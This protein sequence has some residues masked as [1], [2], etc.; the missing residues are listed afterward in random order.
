MAKKSV[1]GKVQQAAVP[2][3]AGYVEL[4]EDLKRRIRE[5]RVR[6]A[7]SVNRELVLLYWHI[8]REILKRQKQEGWGA[9]VIERL[10]RDLRREFPD[11]K[12]F[13]PRNLKYMRAFAEAYPDEQFVQEVLAQITWYHNITLLE[14]VKD[15]TERAWYIQQ[16]IEHGWSRNVLVHQIESGLYHRQGRAITNFERTL[17]APQSDLARSLIKDPYVFDFL[18]L[19][20]E[21]QE[22]ELERAL[23]KHLRD[24]LLELGTGFAFVGSQC[25]LEVGGEDFYIDLLFYH[26]K[27]RCFVVIDLKMR[28]FR[29]EDAGKMNFYLS[30]VDDLLR[31]PEDRPS[32][33]LILCKTKNR[34]VVEYSLRDMNKPIGTASYQLTRTLPADLQESLPSVEE[35]EAELGR[36][37]NEDK[38]GSKKNLEELGYGE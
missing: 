5:A 27:L 20:P 30:A 26:L 6:A 4:L 2:L 28:E 31:H 17:P 22:R 1:K 29:P 35:L 15:P 9:K 13:S 21:V 23:L 3:P 34:L 8:G 16:T 12:G 7:L 24:F 33:G 14:K 10:A 37:E 25:H 32:I 36:V 19:G 18:S 11:M 38:V